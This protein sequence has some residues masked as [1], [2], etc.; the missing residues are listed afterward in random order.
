MSANVRHFTEIDVKV[1]PEVT[2]LMGVM[3]SKADR[4]RIGRTVQEN[5]ASLPGLRQGRAT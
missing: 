1:L 3:I 2:M 5:G 4:N